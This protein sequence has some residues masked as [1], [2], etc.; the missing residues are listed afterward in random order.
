MDARFR[1]ITTQPCTFLG[2]MP[3]TTAMGEEDSREVVDS[4]SGAEAVVE[5]LKVEGQHRLQVRTQPH[6]ALRD[7]R[8]QS[9]MLGQSPVVAAATAQGAFS[10]VGG[11]DSVAAVNQFNLADKVSYVST[12]GGAMLEYFEGKTLPGIA[13]I[14]E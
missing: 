3:D 12:G 10:L 11:G 6:W 4:V 1:K 9:P 13:A 5:L 14:K 2:T 7:C 8:R